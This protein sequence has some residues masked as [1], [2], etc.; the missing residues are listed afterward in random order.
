MAAATAAVTLGKLTTATFVGSKGV[1]RKV[2]SQER[3]EEEVSV[4]TSGEG[5][6]GAYPR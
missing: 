4:G 1:K 2:A 6:G 5:K 3:E